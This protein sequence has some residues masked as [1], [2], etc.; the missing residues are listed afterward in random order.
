MTLKPVGD[1][2]ESSP[3]VIKSVLLEL[4]P[5]ERIYASLLT[6]LIVSRPNVQNSSLEHLR[7]EK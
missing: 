5:I 1:I 6:V 4:D 2:N 3:G 7:I